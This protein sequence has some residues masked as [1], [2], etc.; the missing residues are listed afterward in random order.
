MRIK[1]SP[2]LIS[3]AR[4]LNVMPA[5][6]GLG[7]AKIVFWPLITGKGLKDARTVFQQGQEDDI[8]LIDYYDKF[9]PDNVSNLEKAKAVAR[10]VNIR[11]S[12]KTDLDNYSRAEY[13]NSPIN[14]QNL[15]SGDCDDYSVLITK[16]L[17]LLG[18]K[19]WEVF[20]AVGYVNYPQGGRVLHAYT[21]VFDVNTFSFYPIE[22]SFYPT[23]VLADAGV[24][25]ILENEMY[26]RPM[27]MVNDKKAYSSMPFLRFIK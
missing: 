17:R 5:I 12:Y 14:V 6:I 24:K 1:Y 25:T 4:K 2:G 26:D 22:G 27:W 21:I 9:V 16:V 3:L 23:T 19:D 13:W 20:T 11:L 8:S 10:A 15:E 7:P 18:L